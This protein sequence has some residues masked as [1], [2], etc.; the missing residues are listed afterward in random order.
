MAGCYR[1]QDGLLVTRSAALQSILVHGG[2]AKGDPC[3]AWLVTPSPSLHHS[4][5]VLQSSRSDSDSSFSGRCVTSSLPQ[6]GSRCAHAYG[7]LFAPSGFCTVVTPVAAA[8]PLAATVTLARRLALAAPTVS[9]AVAAAT[10]LAAAVPA[11][12]TPTVAAL[13]RVAAVATDLTRR[14]GSRGAAH[15]PAVAVVARSGD[16]L[17]TRRVALV[18]E[19]G[20]VDRRFLV[21]IIRDA[22]QLDALA[23]E[24]VCQFGWSID[25]V[26]RQVELEPWRRVLCS[27]EPVSLPVRVLYQLRR[28]RLADVVP[29]EQQLRDEVIRR[30]GAVVL[31]QTCELIYCRRVT[32]LVI[33]KVHKRRVTPL[34]ARKSPR[35]QRE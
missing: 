14:R 15:R 26:V 12:V 4:R 35:C 29:I 23:L 20:Q 10:P 19:V 9:I 34:G 8:A 18:H 32:Q 7:P 24:L 2:V 27:F 11:P 1:D 21:V 28:A 30:K 5:P 6:S 22:G 33:R 31:H 16:R 13:E 3:A 17:L 25:A